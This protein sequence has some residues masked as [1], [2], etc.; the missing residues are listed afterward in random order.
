MNPTV[1]RER[2]PQTA[3]PTVLSSA[4]QLGKTQGRLVVS[5]LVVVGLLLRLHLLNQSLSG[6]EIS[7]YWIVVG[8]GLG[9]AIWL[10]HSPQ[11]TT[12][13]LFFVAAWLTQ[14]WLGNP[15]ESIRLVPLV[16]GTVTIPMTYVLGVR[17]VGRNAAVVGAA[18]IT[19]SPFLITYSVTARAYMLATLLVLLAGWF[20]L[21]FLD[22]GEWGWAAGYAACTCAALYTHYVVVFVLGAQLA[23]AFLVHPSARRALVV[24]N[25][26]ALLGFAPWAGH[27]LSDFH[28]PNSIAY[29]NHFDANTV[30]GHVLPQFSLGQG[31]YAVSTVPGPVGLALL[32]AGAA[33]AVVGL[34]LSWRTGRLHLGR[35]SS[36]TWLVVILALATPV[37]A[38]LYSLVGSDVFDSRNMII[39]WP[40]LALTVGAVVARIPQPLRLL[41]PVLLAG[42]LVFG[43]VKIFDSVYQPPDVN[44]AASYVYRVGSSGDPVVTVPAYAYPLTEEDVAFADMGLSTSKRFVT[45]RIGAPPRS[46]SVHAA[47]TQGNAWPKT[48]HFIAPAVIAKEAAARASGRGRTLFYIAGPTPLAEYGFFPYTPAAMF[49]SALPRTMRPFRETIF[50]GLD[51]TAVIGVFEFHDTAPGS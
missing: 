7:T 22:S 49:L 11:E 35:F 17:T 19:L 25:L 1:T 23:W 31:Y 28:G 30:F 14:G 24:S 20:L 18:L 44:A 40:A 6:D 12:P 10:S 33:V 16:A 2:P 50:P 41:A 47:L 9:Q 8:H 51:G 43:T 15:G 5:A 42:G 37:G 13:P 26:V 29:Y 38:G 27:L 45:Y 3:P 34:A 39:S 21:R 46:A 48:I 4:W 32:A 36:R